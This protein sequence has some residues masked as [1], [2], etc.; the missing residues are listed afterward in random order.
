MGSLRRGGS[1]YTEAEALNEL[2]LWLSATGGGTDAA[3]RRKAAELVPSI[4][5]GPAAHSRARWALTSLSHCEFGI[6]ADRGWRVAPPV[7]AAGDMQGEVTAI[8]CGAR[9]SPLVERVRAASAGSIAIEAQIGAPDR[10]AIR[11]ASASELIGAAREAGVPI[12]W[13]APLA[14]LAAFEAPPLSSFPESALPSGGWTV[15][16]LSRSRMAWV[17]SSVIEAAR[18]R[19]GLFRFKSEYATRHIYRQDGVTR[20]APPSI[21]KYW[22]FG[23]RQRAMRL[24]L[25][26]GVVS[27]PATAKPPGLVDR[28]L[29]ACS[30]RLPKMADGR[31]TYA[32]VTA[33]VAAAVSAALRGV[34]EG[35]E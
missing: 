33:G 23:R 9:S 7:L 5:S 25:S 6:D 31:L 14:I 16:R 30:G 29:A 22:L 10:I 3:F 24:D 13:N 11:A 19:R 34:A 2:L 17:E 8:L 26:R 15:W 35:A 12:Q 27:F 32:D 4:R 21:A 1:L 28:A 20:D 18:T